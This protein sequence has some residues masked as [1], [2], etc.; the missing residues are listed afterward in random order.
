MMQNKRED[1]LAAMIGIHALTNR[2][3]LSSS[4]RVVGGADAITQIIMDACLS[5]NM[6]VQEVRNK[7]IEQH[8]DPLRD[9]SEAC[10]EELQI[11]GKP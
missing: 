9:F 2:I 1:A 10:R 5:P 8:I 4:A 6:T 3:H 7:W 11:F